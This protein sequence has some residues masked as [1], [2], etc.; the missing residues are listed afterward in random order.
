MSR[1]RYRLVIGVAVLVAATLVAA[2][3]RHSMQPVPQPPR[4]GSAVDFPTL[5]PGAALP[6]GA[7]CARRVRAS[8][9]AEINP[10]NEAYNRTGGQ[11]V[12]PSLFPQ[13]DSPQAKLLAARIDG[14]FTGTTRQILEWAAC[15]W[16]I[17]QDVV[18]AQAAAESSWQQGYLGD[19]TT[20]A[21]R[22]P[23]GHGPGADGV[24]GECP[25]SY[26]ILQVKYSEWQAAWPGI[27]RS[28]AMNADVTYAIWRSCFDGDE[29]WLNHTA[30]S[31]RPYRAG[32]LWGCV[33]RWYAGNWY[34]PA[35]DQYI[36]QVQ[37]LL[38][39]EVWERPAFSSAG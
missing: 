31:A 39:E 8:R 5:P 23:P 35:A 6:S 20:D 26:G 21:G 25:Q 36:E 37:R 2:A 16:G 19:W 22:C 33:G 28:T 34:T 27:A 15:K 14:D 18:F 10:A 30:S 13:G 17:S 9:D 1:G 12:G 4:A 11:R 32:D 24:P 38:E 3:V 7:E 29:I